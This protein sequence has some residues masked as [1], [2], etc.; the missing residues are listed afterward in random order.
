MKDAYEV[1]EK[2]VC[3]KFVKVK[4]TRLHVNYEYEIDEINGDEIT[5]YDGQDTAVTVDKDLLNKHFIHAY[6][7]TCHSYQGSSI[8][9]KITIFDWRFKHVNRKWLYTSVTRATEL[10]NVSFYV[11]KLVKDDDDEELLKRYLEM[12]IANY[13]A[14]DL[15]HGRTITDSYVT[16]DWLK[17]QFGKHCSDCGDCLRYDVIGGYKVNSNLTADRL[18]CSVCHNL[19]NIVPL[20]TT[21]NSRS[22]NWK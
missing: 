22:S 14:Q 4:K 5:I 12:K 8:D 17:Q 18:D 21:C 1:G 6:C 15:Q 20:C 11:G 10:K 3:R 2:V 13:I 9:D 19:N 7:R 16:T